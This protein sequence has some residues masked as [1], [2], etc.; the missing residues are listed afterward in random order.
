MEPSPFGQITSHLLAVVGNWGGR[1]Q[2]GASFERPTDACA[3]TPMHA[4]RM[5]VV[6]PSE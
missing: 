4:V 1:R 2:D 3:G 6:D 5:G